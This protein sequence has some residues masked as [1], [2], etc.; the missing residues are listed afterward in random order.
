MLGMLRMLFNMIQDIIC[1]A[2]AKQVVTV[3]II[4]SNQ[5][6]TQLSSLCPPKKAYRV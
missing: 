5:S 2:A 6:P 3:N 4:N 1:C